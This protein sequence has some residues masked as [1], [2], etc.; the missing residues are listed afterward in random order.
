VNGFRQFSKEWQIL[1]FH[2]DG[3]MDEWD[4]FEWSRNAI[5]IGTRKQAKWYVF[6]A[7]VWQ[8]FLKSLRLYL[9]VL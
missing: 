8:L 9:S 6:T 1:L 5:H 3:K 7:T 4:E 2:Y